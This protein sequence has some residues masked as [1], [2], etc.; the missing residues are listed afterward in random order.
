VR[1]SFGH[2][3]KWKK[4][5]KLVFTE[6]KKKRKEKK[7]EKQ[8]KSGSE[9]EMTAGVPKKKT[10][11]PNSLTARVPFREQSSVFACSRN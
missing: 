4:G 3:R 8:G 5:V 9:E 6:N 2:L 11:F 7:K 1:L 10:E